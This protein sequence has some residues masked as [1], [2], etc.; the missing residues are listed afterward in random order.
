MVKNPPASPGETGGLELHLWVRKIP[1]VENGNSLQ[2]SCLKNATDRGA[3][4]AIKSTGSQRVRHNLATE[5][6]DKAV[7]GTWGLLM[8]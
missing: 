1:R 2:H 5:H 4:Q 6:E 7:T 8:H 3:W